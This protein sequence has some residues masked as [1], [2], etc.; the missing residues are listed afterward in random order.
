MD[1]GHELLELL[2]DAKAHQSVIVGEL[3]WLP[4]GID[5]PTWQRWIDTF[6]PSEAF[7]AQAKARIG[8]CQGIESANLAA[9]AA[10]RR[11]DAATYPIT[12]LGM[13]LVVLSFG[14]LLSYHPSVVDASHPETEQTGTRNR[15]IYISLSLIV[16]F[17]VLDLIWTLLVSATGSMHELNP[18]GA[19][20]IANPGWLV[21]FK[22]ATTSVAVGLLLA[23]RRF[24]IARRAAWWGCLLLTLLAIRWLVFSSMFV[25]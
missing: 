16:A 9:G 3:D 2:S 25:A 5:I 19:R 8:Q 6:A 14:H 18:L 17:S 20:L 24:P 21:T 10:V 13:V 4:P 11:L 12:V 23:L 1:T 7:L 15:V 22:L